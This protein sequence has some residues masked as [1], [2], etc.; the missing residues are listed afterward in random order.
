MEAVMT[1]SQAFF[2]WLLQTTLIASLVICLI[3]LM[4]KLLGGRLGPRWS[5]ALW[6]VL[7]VRMILPWSPSSRLSLSNLIPSLQRQTQSQQSYGSIEVQEVP[8]PKQAAGTPETLMGQEQESESVTQEQFAPRLQTQ[9]NAEARSRFHLVSIFRI[10]PI[11]WLAGAIVIGVYLLVSDLALWRIVKRDRPLVNQAMLELF[12]EC[13]AQMGVQSLVVVVPSD[14]VRSPGLFGFVRPRL[15]LPRQMLDNATAEEMR[16]VFLHE[17]AHLRRHDIYLGWLTSLLQVLHWFN[18]LVW[19]AFYRM[20]A[21]RELACDALVLTRTGQD[22]SQ[23]YGGAIIELVRRFSRSRPLPAM[24]GIIESKSQLKRRIAMITKFKAGSYGLSVAG[25]ALVIVLACISLPDAPRVEASEKPTVN[26]KGRP[27]LRRVINC[28][29]NA[30]ISPDNRFVCYTKYD[31][32][33]EF[34]VHE[35]DT[36]KTHVINASAGAAGHEGDPLY[37]IFSPDGQTIAYT[38]VDEQ[39]DQTNKGHQPSLCLIGA[40]GSNKR[41]LCHGISPEFWSPDGKKILGMTS[42]DNEGPIYMVWISAQNGS[43]EERVEFPTKRYQVISLSPDGRYL[44]FD[45]PQEGDPNATWYAGKWDIFALDLN[46][47][48][49]SAIVRN[50][51]GEVLLGWAP[52]GKY[53]LFLSDRMGTW[54]A[55]LQP[56]SD[57][58]PAGQ[59]KLISRNVG[60]VSPGGFAQ[61]GSYYYEV[62]YNFSLIYLAEI[63]AQAAK[64]VSVFKALEGTGFDKCCDWSPDGR[65][66]AYASEN[67]DRPGPVT[68]HVLDVARG[69]ER[70]FE[71]DPKLNIVGCLRWAPDGKSLLASGV[72]NWSL[73]HDGNRKEGIDSRVYRIDVESGKNSILMQ[74][75]R[76]Y[77]N[78]AELSPDGRTLFY[79]CSSALSAEGKEPSD[80]SRLLIRRDLDSGQEKSVFDPGSSGRFYSSALSPT[81]D[82]VAIT[83][84]EKTSDTKKIILIP[85]IGGQPTEL[86]RWDT[87]PGRIGDVAWTP[88][89]KGILFVLQKDSTPIEL[90]HVAL[91]APQPRKIMETDLG[92]WRSGLRVAPDGR[93]V[94][95]D[96]SRRYHE[97]W[98][99]ENILP[100]ELDK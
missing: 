4:Q 17:L 93:H 28:T 42:G 70:T 25:I 76:R 10:L 86:V 24:A 27:T 9:F 43:A 21:D 78:R 79:S 33:G 80:S 65:F 94:A 22:K 40:D 12:E 84:N 50:P 82:L 8:P 37:P 13:K 57:G 18:P 91:D 98:V 87:T 39:Q 100:K 85:S 15:L 67:P 95:F 16:Y 46:T 59:A 62:A 88:D 2:G 51:A 3:L 36:G 96:A 58:A 75:R 69:N 83:L 20:R 72:Y 11:F 44:A 73:G 77:V 38:V 63:D 19:F 74:S 97:L 6:L 45:R 31:G 49:E 26:D 64:V 55:W 7:L 66:A 61:N 35:L 23:E 89:A 71:L 41:V 30:A 14:R 92:G 29:A 34:I 53:I 48:Q 1:Y 54:D 5:Y 90:W 52:G 47:G 68:I 60:H 99:M 56:V 81:G 32:N